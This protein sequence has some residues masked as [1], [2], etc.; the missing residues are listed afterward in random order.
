MGK[1]HGIVAK[2]TLIGLCRGRS[3]LLPMMTGVFRR[4]V[5]QQVVEAEL[6]AA[7]RSARGDSA[8]GDR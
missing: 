7:A 2:R 4:L 5:G 3:L 1:D 8:H 6:L